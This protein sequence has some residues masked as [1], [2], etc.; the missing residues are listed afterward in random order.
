MKKIGIIGCGW[1]GI[2]LAE[3]LVLNNT[4]YATTTSEEKL[5]LLQ[6]KGLNP[7]VI[8]FSEIQSHEAFA[9]WEDTEPFS[10]LIITVPLFSK[11]VAESIIETRIEN[12]LAFVGNF[13]EQI[14]LMSSTGVYPDVARELTE[15]DLPYENV[16]SEFRLKNQCPQLN[17][18]RLAGLMGDNRQLSNYK[19]SNPEAPVNHVHYADVC[20]TI[21]LMISQQLHDKLY[22]IVAPNHPSKTDVIN[23]QTGIGTGQLQH[24]EGR[25]ISSQ[26]IIA[27]LNYT[28][29]YPDPRYFHLK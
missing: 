7:S 12:L 23:A 6:S 10:V 18:L 21:E 15:A 11:R 27:E 22:N 4:V 24:T 29:K 13:K 28:F 2:R 3:K 25:I 20:A 16:Q 8:N 5:Q 26:K 19:V 9:E 14:F 1:L 17:I